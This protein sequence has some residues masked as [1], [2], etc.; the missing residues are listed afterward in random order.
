[1]AEAEVSGVV[2]GAENF[3]AKTGLLERREVRR[4]KPESKN[5][6]TALTQLRDRPSSEPFTLRDGKT[7]IHAEMQDLQGKQ[8]TKEEDSTEILMLRTLDTALTK[9]E[10]GDIT[11]VSIGAVRD[12]RGYFGDK[13]KQWDI[14]PD[15]DAMPDAD[16]N[17][18]IYTAVLT[19]VVRHLPTAEA[20]LPEYPTYTG[21]NLEPVLK[22][23]SEKEEL[24][25]DDMEKAFAKFAETVA[26]ARKEAIAQSPQWV[27]HKDAINSAIKE[28]EGVEFDK[29]TPLLVTIKDGE[30]TT[31]KIDLDQNLPTGEEGVIQFVLD[32]VY[33]LDY[34]SSINGLDTLDSIAPF[35]IEG[36]KKLQEEQPTLSE[37]E[38]DGIRLFV[39]QLE[40]GLKEGTIQKKYHNVLTKLYNFVKNKIETTPIKMERQPGTKE[41]TRDDANEGAEEV[42]D[43]IAA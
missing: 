3:K 21:K 34:F 38:V 43:K 14:V 35:G 22:M 13:I 32:P 17:R 10:D 27:T 19:D 6:E 9:I 40:V 36:I 16:R 4:P 33:D 18:D 12:L 42:T 5:L 24:T 28:W 20:V 23:I 30:T 31:S 41:E 29:L 15:E 2:A 11:S 7:L 26:D 39:G 1:M 25:D 37:Q 8:E